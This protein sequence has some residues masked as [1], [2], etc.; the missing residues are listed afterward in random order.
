M[1]E[2][3]D[4]DVFHAIRDVDSAQADERLADI[5]AQELKSDQAAFIYANKSG[6]QFPA[7]APFR[8]FIIRP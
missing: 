4:S 7:T 8:R 3:V 1:Q 2:S 6:A 5:V